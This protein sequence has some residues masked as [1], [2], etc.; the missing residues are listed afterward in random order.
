VGDLPFPEAAER[1]ERRHEEA[2]ELK[3]SCFWIEL[4]HTREGSE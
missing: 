3:D 1:A 2:V 4:N